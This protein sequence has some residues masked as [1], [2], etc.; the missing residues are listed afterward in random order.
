[1][2]NIQVLGFGTTHIRDLMVM[3][4]TQ[5]SSKPLWWPISQMHICVSL[6][7]RVKPSE[8]EFS[9]QSRSISW[10]LMT[11]PLLSPGHQQRWHWLCMIKGSLASTRKD[12]IYLNW[13]SRVLRKYRKCKMFYIFQNKLSMASVNP[14]LTW[15]VC[16]TWSN[17]KS[18]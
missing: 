5:L 8:G 9:W 11:W 14:V 16:M 3:H 13:I 1:M 6:P 10:L 15:R 4:G 18:S 7:R 2:R 17:L 12:S